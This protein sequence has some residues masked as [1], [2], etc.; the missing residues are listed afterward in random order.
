[1]TPPSDSAAPNA[2]PWY[3]QA[4]KLVTAGAST[5]AACVSIF[6]F[7][8]SF[9]IIGSPVISMLR[10]RSPAAAASGAGR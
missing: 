2:T 4:H 7:L 9:G 1:M 8:Y 5:G 10:I 6:S 3:R